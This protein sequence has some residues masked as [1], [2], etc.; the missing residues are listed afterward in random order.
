M[1]YTP[2]LVIGTWVGASSPSVHFS[3]G[4]GSGSSLALPISAYILKG[5]EADA[6]LKANYLTSFEIPDEVYESL[7]SDPY[8]EKGIEGFFKRLFNFKRNKNKTE[9]RNNTVNRR[10]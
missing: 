8:Q 3:S 5:M 1:S 6:K 9:S 7:E 10:N 2:N 4:N